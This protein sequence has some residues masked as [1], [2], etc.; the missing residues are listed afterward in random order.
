ML[1]RVAN[2][3][4]WAARYLERTENTARVISAYTQF[5]MDVP[6]GI[7]GWDRLIKIFEAESDYYSRY[8]RV[9]E[10]NIIKF[11]FLD[12]EN[13]SSISATVRSARENIRTT[14][15]VMPA[16]TW[17][18]LNELKLYLDQEMEAGIRRRERYG[19]LEGVMFRT[20]QLT[21]LF[22]GSMYRDR[23][24]QFLQLGRYLERCDMTT[25]IL[26]VG[27]V[28][29]LTDKQVEDGFEVS[30]W[31][32]LLH[33]LSAMSAYRRET[34]PLID[35]AEVVNFAVD[36]LKF[37]RSVRY[38]L[39]RVEEVIMGLNYNQDCIKVLGS[40]RRML[41]RFDAYELSREQVHTFIDEFQLELNRLNQAI[42]TTWFFPEEH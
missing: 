21:G 29:T 5:I 3:I 39:D 18:L 40:A 12:P 10:P 15:D 13:P 17:E 31:A 23:S 9:T 16:E 25:R 33:S 7:G 32:N 24:Y 28:D 34:G 27:A 22:H 20:L 1:S 30:L 35:S 2:R 26:D 8:S 42:A 37:P 4:F 19:F 38:C 14:R 36:S 41:D 6:K 11:L